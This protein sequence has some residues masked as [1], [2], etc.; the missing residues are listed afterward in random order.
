MVFGASYDDHYRAARSTV[1][2]HSWFDCQPSLARELN[3]V[4]QEPCP[5]NTEIAEFQAACMRTNSTIA[6]NLRALV[7]KIQ[8]KDDPPV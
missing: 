5:T 8:M 6:K 1:T 2:N 7:Y 3:A 4:L